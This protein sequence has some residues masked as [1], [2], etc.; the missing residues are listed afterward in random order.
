M[1]PG[2]EK[3]EFLRWGSVHRNTFINSPQLLTA[4]LEI[5]HVP[6]LYLAGQITGVEGYM[7]STAMGLLAGINALRKEMGKSL[8]PPPPTTA[9]GALV[10]HVVHSQT[11]P[12]QPMNINFGLLNALPAKKI[13][14]SLTNLFHLTI[15]S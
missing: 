8:A 7:E 2:L 13:K 10:H 15:H 1:I 11:T 9:I 14:L 4:S 6:D 3:A 12:F 5:K